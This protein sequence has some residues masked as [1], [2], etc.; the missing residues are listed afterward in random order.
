MD[1]RRIDTALDWARLQV[2]PDPRVTCFDLDWT[3]DDGDVSL[4][5]VVETSHAKRVAV[6]AVESAVR[7]PV[8]ATAVTVLSSDAAELTTTTPELPVRSRPDSDAERVTSVVY[9]MALSGYDRANGWRRVRVPDGYVGWVR[10][11]ALEPSQDV[12]VD[13]DGVLV[14]DV[15]LDEAPGWLPAGVRGQQ[16]RR[17]DDRIELAL[18]TGER[19]RV[20]SDAVVDLDGPA[21]PQEAVSSA[22][23]YLGTPYEWGGMTTDGI[24]CS[25]LVWMAY[26]QTG[27]RLPRDTDQQQRVG[28]EVDREALQAGD[29]LF[30]PGHV[31]MSLGG[32]EFIHA[33]GSANE[34]TFGSLDPASDRYTPDRAA[35]FEVAKRLQR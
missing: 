24:D 35:D 19:F 15:D 12:D 33:C 3:R 17:T 26:W 16:G 5:G 1:R 32:D 7:A 22:R 2:A 4:S 10:G 11:D 28:I 14:R 25:G 31:A 21:D 18:R 29:L 23:R 13:V 20:P 30:F 6:D 8:T 9:G 27:L 34:V